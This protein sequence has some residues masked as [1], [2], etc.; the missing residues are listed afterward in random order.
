[1]TPAAW[2]LPIT[3]LNDEVNTLRRLT[4]DYTDLLF[5]LADGPP[6]L[7]TDGLAWLSARVLDTQALTRRVLESLRALTT[8]NT[9]PT[10]EHLYALKNVATIA[11]DTTEASLILTD[12]VTIFPPTAAIPQTQTAHSVQDPEHDH[13]HD[14]ARQAIAEKLR[15]ASRMLQSCATAC[16]YAAAA[17]TDYPTGTA[18]AT[19]SDNAR[20]TPAAETAHA[21]AP[22]R[23]R[24]LTAA[25]TNALRAIAAGGVTMHEPARIGTAR[26]SAGGGVRITMSTYA[27]LGRLG[28]VDR[29][30]S[31]SLYRGQRLYV[32]DAGHAVLS[33]LPPAAPVA[34][35]A[36]PPPTER[37]R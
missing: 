2:E 27:A 29:D 26:I 37:R 28:L 32:T 4:R 23:S 12:A 15:D 22:T 9:A 36:P 6:H 8:S 16:L 18:P 24:R 11:R 33:A 20:S 3:T 10:P 31:T 5:A 14:R 30:P 19:S 13:E 21:P 25:Q 35:P 1:L 7:D 34:R 17:L